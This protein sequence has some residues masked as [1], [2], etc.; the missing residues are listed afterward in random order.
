MVRVPSAPGAVRRRGH[1]PMRAAMEVAVRL[2]R[3]DGAV[4]VG[5]DAL[6]QRRQV[7]DQAGLTA[8]ERAANL[9]HALEVDPRTHIAGRQAVL[10]DDVITTGASL[11]EATRALRAAGAEVVAAATIAATPLRKPH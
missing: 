5:A 6:R 9:A 7:A 8:R 3:A 4:V 11:T 1:D 2:L 10:V